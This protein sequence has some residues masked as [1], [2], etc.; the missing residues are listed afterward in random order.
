MLLEQSKALF[1]AENY[2]AAW[3]AAEKAI[4]AEPGNLEF[5]KHKATL[6]RYKHPISRTS[7]T[8]SSTHISTVYADY[9]V[10]I[11][12]HPPDQITSYRN[13]IFP[14]LTD[15]LLQFSE[16]LSEFIKTAPEAGYTKWSSQYT[17][18][19]GLW[20]KI[21][22]WDDLAEPHYAKLFL[23]FSS[24]IGVHPEA[25]SLADAIAKKSSGG[26]E[27]HPEEDSQTLTERFNSALQ[28]AG[29]LP[30]GIF[31]EQDRCYLDDS[32]PKRKRK[33]A[34]ANFGKG[35]DSSQLRFLCDE[36]MFLNGK[37][38][39]LLSPTQIAFKLNFDPPQLIEISTLGYIQFEPEMLTSTIKM[40]SLNEHYELELDSGAAKWLYAVLSRMIQ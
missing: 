26:L 2:T 25:K 8:R 14:E 33:N 31:G 30:T 36:T 13:E 12:A 9:T 7:L 16:A 27:S 22:A 15:H 21:A 35:F 1:K 37:K 4:A 29:K 28:H 6:S 34:L 39:V 17:Q 23:F 11:S 3:E 32:I 24:Q 38:G 20:Q 10:A 5:L 19:F 40:G 18:M